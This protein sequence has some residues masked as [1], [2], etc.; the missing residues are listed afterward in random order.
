MSTRPAPKQL[1]GKQQRDSTANVSAAHV[2]ATLPQT[3]RPSSQR[4]AA[5]NEAAPRDNVSRLTTFTRQNDVGALATFWPAHVNVSPR[6]TTR[7]LGVCKASL[8]RTDS[9]ASGLNVKGERHHR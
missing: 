6:Q 3:S 5:R 9:P 4:E 1:G 8:A 2:N 7:V